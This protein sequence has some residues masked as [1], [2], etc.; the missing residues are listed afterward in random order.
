MRVCYWHTITVVS[1]EATG[2]YLQPQASAQPA[3]QEPERPPFL[4]DSAAPCDALRLSIPRVSW[5]LCLCVRSGA[6]T[7]APPTESYADPFTTPFDVIPS[8]LLK[9]D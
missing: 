3:M 6:T 5:A 7:T 4:D 9:R 1:D 8:P 2:F